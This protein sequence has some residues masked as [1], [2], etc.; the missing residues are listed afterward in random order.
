MTKQNIPL[1]LTMISNTRIKTEKHLYTFLIRG[2]MRFIVKAIHIYLVLVREN[3]K[4]MI[5]SW[6]FHA[7]LLA[8]LVIDIRSFDFEA[9]ATEMTVFNLNQKFFIVLLHRRFDRWGRATVIGTPFPFHRILFTDA[10][11]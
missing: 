3:N 5:R 11:E 1:L 6:C 4:M 2:D 7:K 9:H 10:D 8:T